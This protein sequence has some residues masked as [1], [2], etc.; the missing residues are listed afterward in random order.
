MTAK[1]ELGETPDPEAA[2]AF[3]RGAAP[4]RERLRAAAEARDRAAAAAERTA[5]EN[6]LTDRAELRDPDAPAADPDIL[7]E[8]AQ[9][10]LRELSRFDRLIE[11]DEGNAGLLP[12]KEDAADRLEA[13]IGALDERARL[14]RRTAELIRRADENLRSRI[15][16]PV[17]DIFLGYAARLEAV[18]G[19]KMSMD[20]D[21]R[22][23]FERGGKRRSDRHLSA[24]ERS[25]CSLCLRLALAENLYRDG[26]RPLILLDDPFVHLDPE[27][28]RKAADVL[29]ELA[30]NYQILYFCCHPDRDLHSSTEENEK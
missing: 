28:L 29:G 12:E 11:A 4:D 25:L 16:A 9:E 3:F 23:T 30:G 26:E 19:E 24:G 15:I 10:K 2:A 13:E 20:T 8:A 27:H 1:Y 18:L 7:E 6:A 14:L 21:C 22:V 17:R 5:A